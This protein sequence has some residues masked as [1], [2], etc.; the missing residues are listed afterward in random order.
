MRI[1]PRINVLESMQQHEPVL[2]ALKQL[3][4]RDFGFDQ[5]AWRRWW[6]ADGRQLVGNDS[7]LLEPP[8]VKQAQPLQREQADTPK[9]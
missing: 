5:P 9:D 8:A 1:P 6:D 2:L 7:D 3:S 4:G